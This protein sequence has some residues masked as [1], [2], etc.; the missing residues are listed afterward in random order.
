MPD[1][2]GCARVWENPEPCP[3]YG[4]TMLTPA[5]TPAR[6][7]ASRG[8]LGKEDWIAAATDLLI[9]GSVEAIRVE[10]LAKRL[11]IT[12]GSFYYHF[13][14]RDDLLAQ[15]LENWREWATAQT[16][17]QLQVG[18]ADPR[19]V[20]ENMLELPFHGSSARRASMIEL[21][22]RIWARQ[23]ESVQRVVD[24]VDKQRLA[25]AQR[26]FMALGLTPSKARGKAFATYSYLISQSMLWHVGD[27]A[28]K[29]K[30]RE[31]MREVLLGD[32]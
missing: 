2:V 21:S 25:Y 19:R 4:S 16:I 28:Y 1:C 23:D 22:V 27:A 10:S 30:M 17:R 6:K 26:C 8:T 31:Y 9:D 29:K 12:T 18:Q 11:R 15:V 24:A 13:K 3:F 5:R 14:D 7:R 20:I 32:I